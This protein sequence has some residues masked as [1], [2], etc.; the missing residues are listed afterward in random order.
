MVYNQVCYLEGIENQRGLHWAEATAGWPSWFPHHC[1]QRAWKHTW[2]HPCPFV[3]SIQAGI[4]PRHQARSHDSPLYHMIPH[5]RHVLHPV[6]GVGHQ[7]FHPRLA[8]NGALT[9]ERLGTL[10]PPKHEG[11]SGDWKFIYEFEIFWNCRSSSHPCKPKKVIEKG[12]QRIMF[13]SRP[14]MTRWSCLTA[15]PISLSENRVPLN[16]VDDHHLLIK[17]AMLGAYP[18]FR[19]LPQKCW[20]YPIPHDNP[21]C[22]KFAGNS[23]YHPFNIPL[24]WLF[25]TMSCYPMADCMVCQHFP[26]SEPTL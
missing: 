22:A 3:G 7:T 15:T 26:L 20:L 9:G 11:S 6:P 25:S 14:K 13:L 2:W 16:L 17:N 4:Q 23:V 12:L 8:S 1:K 5:Q 10:P 21:H 18:I 24:W 19:H